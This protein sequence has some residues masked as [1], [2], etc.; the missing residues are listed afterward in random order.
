MPSSMDIPVHDIG[1]LLEIQE[2]SIVWFL[3]LTGLI[4][5]I[6]SVLLKQI[7]SR[8]KSKEL[9]ERSVRYED[10]CRIDLSNPKVAAYEICKQGSFFAH[11]NEQTLSSYRILFEDLERYKY[12]PKVEPMDEECLAL[13]EAYCH[14]I[15]V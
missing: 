6:I 2:Y 5:V 1:P 8:K 7:R 10:F 12:A 13:Y 3:I 14:M 11:D 4:L 15:V 9:D